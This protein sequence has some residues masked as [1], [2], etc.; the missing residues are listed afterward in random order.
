MKIVGA[1][2]QRAS[3]QCGKADLFVRLLFE[4]VKEVLD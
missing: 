1:A 3:A 4:T 2:T